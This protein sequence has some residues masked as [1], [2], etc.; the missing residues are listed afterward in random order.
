MKSKSRQIELFAVADREDAPVDPAN[1]NPAT[2]R[3]SDPAESGGHPPTALRGEATDAGAGP[4][5]RLCNW[6][7]EV[8]IRGRYR[9]E[10]LLM[11][12]LTS[13]KYHAWWNGQEMIVKDGICCGCATALKEG[14]VM[15]GST[16][17]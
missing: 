6:C 14:R 15:N 17:L 9:K 11:V 7:G 13:G 12:A 4:V 3:G 16:S 8:S 10:D 5:I 2:E 1:P